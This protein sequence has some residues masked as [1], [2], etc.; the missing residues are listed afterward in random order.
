MTDQELAGIERDLRAQQQN[1]T[2]ILQ[3]LQQARAAGMNVEQIC[4]LWRMSI[5]KIKRC[6]TRTIPT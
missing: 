6:T 2:F 3:Q 4:V 5:K 1:R